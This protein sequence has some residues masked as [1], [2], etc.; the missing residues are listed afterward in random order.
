MVKIAGLAEFTSYRSQ[1]ECLDCSQEVKATNLSFGVRLETVYRT[2][3]NLF[4]CNES[5][6]PVL[7]TRIWLPG[8]GCSVKQERERSYTSSP[9]WSHNLP[10][11]IHS[12]PRVH[13]ASKNITLL[14]RAPLVVFWSLQWLRSECSRQRRV[15]DEGRN[16]FNF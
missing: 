3:L 12:V 16:S 1:N 2:G 6:G 11:N 13:I 15:P 9:C 4:E 8:R 10:Q 7:R 5:G 14:I